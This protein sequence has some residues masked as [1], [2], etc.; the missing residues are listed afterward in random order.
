MGAG[1]H[2]SSVLYEYPKTFVISKDNL[3]RSQIKR[4]KQQPVRSYFGS[5]RS[6]NGIDQVKI[7]MDPNPNVQRVYLLWC[8]KKQRYQDKIYL[9]DELNDSLI[10]LE[11]CP[12]CG[13][14]CKPMLAGFI[15][16]GGIGLELP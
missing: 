5:G 16:D 14:S 11:I 8:R 2:L 10:A 7:S 13:E 1:T 12:E 3:S 15:Y 6:R 9:R 4:S